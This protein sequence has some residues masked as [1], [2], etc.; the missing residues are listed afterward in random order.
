[1]KPWALPLLAAAVLLTVPPFLLAAS[2]SQPD[3][4]AK[5][6]A[7]LIARK[8]L[9]DFLTDRTF[10][11]KEDRFRGEAQAV[12]PKKNVEVEVDDLTLTGAVAT[13][14]VLAKA[15]FKIEGT[16]RQDGEKVNASAIADLEFELEVTVDIRRLGDEVRVRVR[17]ET[18]ECEVEE[19][20][21]LKPADLSGADDLIEEAF[22]A[23]REEF[24]EEINEWLAENEIDPNEAE[25]D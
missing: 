2:R 12:K 9:V 19:V 25:E 21:R 4:A 17:V 11:I 16:V 7:A 14:K 8:I 24:L 18:L 20:R 15:P 10:K 3:A 13:G 5:R 23:H 22:R 6:A 1:M